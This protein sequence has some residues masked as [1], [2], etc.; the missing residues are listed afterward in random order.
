MSAA[1]AKIPGA[2]MLLFLCAAL[3]LALGRRVD[4]YKSFTEGARRGVGMAV[5]TLPHMVAM[6]AAA[7]RFR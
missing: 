2:A 6:L 3:I 4:A 7:R 5:R 1:L